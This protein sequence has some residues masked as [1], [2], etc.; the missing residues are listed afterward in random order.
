[1]AGI[2][3]ETETAPI[4]PIIIPPTSMAGRKLPSGSSPA[5]VTWRPAV[6]RGECVSHS[7]RDFLRFSQQTAKK[8]GGKYARNHQGTVGCGIVVSRRSVI[9]MRRNELFGRGA[10]DQYLGLQRGSLQSIPALSPSQQQ[11]MLCGGSCCTEDL[12]AHPE[13]YVAVRGS[14]PAAVKTERVQRYSI[15]CTGGQRPCTLW[16]GCRAKMR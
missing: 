10:A 4:R 7:P 1:M 3:M 14:V 13:E 5:D 8:N 16:S 2:L 12:R 6:T 9:W 15:T 11:L